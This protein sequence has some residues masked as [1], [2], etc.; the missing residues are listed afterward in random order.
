MS[1]SATRGNGSRPMPAFCRRPTVQDG[2]KKETPRLDHLL[3]GWTGSRDRVRGAR[4]LLSIEGADVLNGD[5]V[6]F[7][8][9]WVLSALLDSSLLDGFAAVRVVELSRVQPRSAETSQE[10]LL[11]ARGQWPPG[12]PGVEL[13]LDAT[14]GLIESAAAFE[15]LVSLHIEREDPDV[16]FIGAPVD[17][18]R[19]S[20]WLRGISPEATW[21]DTRSRWRYSQVTRVDLAGRYTYALLE[22]VGPPNHDDW[23][24]CTTVATW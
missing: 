12:G 10:A 14:G 23:D 15:S 11:R 24:R 1:S 4:V 13:D 2:A 18:R 6:Q 7:G 19:H 17:S 5:V 22:V 21:D 3:G 16:C 20:V 8:E 9:K